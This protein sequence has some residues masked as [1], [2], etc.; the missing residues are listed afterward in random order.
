MNAK[1]KDRAME[2]NKIRQEMIV[3][4]V[5]D[6]LKEMKEEIDSALSLA[7]EMKKTSMEPLAIC[8][9]IALKMIRVSQ[10]HN[11]IGRQ[12]KRLMTLQEAEQKDQKE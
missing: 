11:S 1:E 7:D 4:D 10:H 6:S 5:F 3:E 8:A 9:A 12:L 2:N